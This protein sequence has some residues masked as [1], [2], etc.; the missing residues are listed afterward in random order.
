M[1]TTKNYIAQLAK[2]FPTEAKMLARTM[3]F[4]CPECEQ[5]FTNP[6][7]YAYGHDCEAQ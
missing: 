5:V 2:I 4:T 6:D 3:S 1:T 7:D